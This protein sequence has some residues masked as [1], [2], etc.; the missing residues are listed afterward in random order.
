MLIKCQTNI[1]TPSLMDTLLTILRPVLSTGINLSVKKCIVSLLQAMIVTWSVNILKLASE[2]VSVA[3]VQSIVRRLERVL[4]RSLIKQH[5]AAQS[6]VA[7]LPA[8]GRFILSMD[9]TSWRLGSFK[10]YVLAVG[11][12]FDGVSLPICFLF[13]PGADI[14]SFVEEIE[15]MESVVSIIGRGRVKCLVADREFGNT[16]FIKWLQFN[17][18]K[19]CL[20]LRENLY[21][22]KE[23]QKKGRKL[24][25]VLSSLRLGESV[26]LKDIYLVRKNTRVRIY[27]TRRYGRNG[28]ES[29][30]ILA[31]PLECD[32]TEALY[33]KRWTIETAFRGLKTAGFNMEDTHLGEE[34]FRNMLTMLMI[35]FA[36][37][38]IEGLLK[39]Q[40]LPIPLMSNRNVRRISVFRYGYIN[41]LHDFWA[42]VKIQS[43]LP[44]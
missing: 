10:Y 35:A 8:S 26:V 36:A 40:T 5:E 29:L 25:A 19:Y 37:A 20:R 21:I 24:S 12:C 6:I 18:I 31:S 7:S 3:K 32:Y 41:L 17:N 16:N 15:I 38:F 39:I 1:E 43:V 30:I 42:N 44:T 33:R 27:A 14:T 34:R 28:E 22:R 4:S 9:G 11:I 23:G 2:F 13:L